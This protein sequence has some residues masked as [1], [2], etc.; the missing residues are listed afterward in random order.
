MSNFVF[1]RE[2]CTDRESRKS[3]VVGTRA[4]CA[5][6]SRCTRK[7]YLALNEHMSDASLADRSA[8]VEAVYEHVR[9]MGDARSKPYVVSLK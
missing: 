8:A 2:K 5:I 3:K 6:G 9:N 7:T 4:Y 1:L